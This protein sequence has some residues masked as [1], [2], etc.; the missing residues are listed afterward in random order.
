[1]G[2]QFGYAQAKVLKAA[3]VVLAQF[4]P[5]GYF[6]ST[7]RMSAVGRRWWRGER[8]KLGRLPS[9]S[10]GVG[11]GQAAYGKSRWIGV[12]PPREV[13]CDLP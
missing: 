5:P 8:Q 6:D 1:M 11:N 12:V 13:T 4:Q 9:G 10:F 2:F 3:I 7:G